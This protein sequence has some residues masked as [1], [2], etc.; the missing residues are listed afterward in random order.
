MAPACS[1]PVLR[2]F[3]RPGEGILSSLQGPPPG[4]VSVHGDAETIAAV[5][6]AFP[7]A[8]VNGAPVG[9]AFA[10]VDLVVVQDRVLPERRWWRPWRR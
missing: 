3:G 9:G 1:P 8:E 6:A 10:D 5:M 4:R 2:V 7:L